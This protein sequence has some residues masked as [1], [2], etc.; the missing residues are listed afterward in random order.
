MAYLMLFGLGNVSVFFLSFQLAIKKSG[1]ALATVLMFT[2]PIWVA[3]F[4]RII[5]QESIDRAKL[6]AILTALCGVVLVCFSGGSLGGDISYVGLGSGIVCGLFYACQ[7][8]FY[9]W[10]KGHFSTAV[11]FAFTFLPAAAVLACF[12]DFQPISMAGWIGIAVPAFLSTYAAYYMYGQSLFYLT[13]VQASVIGNLEPVAGTLLSW[14]FWNENFTV[15]G[16]IGCA[17]VIGSVAIMALLGRR[18]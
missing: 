9:S 7:F 12:A 1:S 11:L 6:T 8:I 3:I 13:P 10:W 14:W 18:Q 5:F 4:S 17:F 2:A 15:S 16:W